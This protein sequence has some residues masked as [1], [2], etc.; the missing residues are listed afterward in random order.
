M[1]IMLTPKKFR[2]RGAHLPPHVAAGGVSAGR[3]AVEAVDRVLHDVRPEA[4]TS[5]LRRSA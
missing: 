4:H 3:C 1:H 5:T 2:H